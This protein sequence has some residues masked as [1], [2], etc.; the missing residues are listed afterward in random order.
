MTLEKRTSEYGRWGVF[1]GVCGSLVV[2]R[3]E[4]QLLHFFSVPPTPVLSK[5]FTPRRHTSS[6]RE[7]S[8]LTDSLLSL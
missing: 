7:D 4:D 8:S 3:A 2:F 6:G 5:L 1:G